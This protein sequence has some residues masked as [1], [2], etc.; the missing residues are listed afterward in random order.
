M[1]DGTTVNHL[2][3]Y[4]QPQGNKQQMKAHYYRLSDN[5]F[6]L[7]FWSEDQTHMQE[8]FLFSQK[9][10]RDLS[11]S[12]DTTQN[13]R[14][15]RKATLFLAICTFP[16]TLLICI[17]VYLEY[18]NHYAYFSPLIVLKLLNSSQKKTHRLAIPPAQKPVHL[19]IHFYD[20]NK[21]CIVGYSTSLRILSFTLLIYCYGTLLHY[22]SNNYHW[23]S[24]LTVTSEFFRILQCILRGS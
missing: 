9:K 15:K 24:N 3:C 6:V 12:N 18:L 22:T 19:C 16:S 11:N 2:S 20:F 13:T 5:T 7:P 21:W 8:R 1:G 23:L 4:V 10:D 14:K 17:H